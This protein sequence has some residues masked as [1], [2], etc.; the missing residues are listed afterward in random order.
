M[1]SRGNHM[2]DT[3]AVRKEAECLQDG[4]KEWFYNGKRYLVPIFGASSPDNLLDLAD[5]MDKGEISGNHK[6]LA[7]FLFDFA[8]VILSIKND[9]ADDEIKE[10]ANKKTVSELYNLWM[11]VDEEAKKN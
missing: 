9:V 2:I 6:V 10:L 7:T 5:E 11:D 8:K 4:T 3:D 1:V